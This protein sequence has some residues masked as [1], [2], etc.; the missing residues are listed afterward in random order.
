MYVISDSASRYST[1]KRADLM[2]KAD[3]YAESRGKVA[4]AVPQPGVLSGIDRGGVVEYRFRLVDKGGAD[5]LAAQATPAP[6]PKAENVAPGVPPAQAVKPA[7]QPPKEAQPAPQPEKVS[8]LYADL[9]K[10]DDL[11]KRG[12]LT[13]EEFQVQK[14]KLL[15]GPRK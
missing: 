14:K 11:R 2:R 8:D 9:L 15:D 12:I 4:V 1:G 5:A 10:L 7:E 6:R 13:E 3:A